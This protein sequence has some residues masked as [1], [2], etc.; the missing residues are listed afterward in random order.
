MRST[1]G[2]RKRDGAWTIVHGHTSVPFNMDGSFTAAM[3]LEP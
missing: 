2:F 3:D 1:L